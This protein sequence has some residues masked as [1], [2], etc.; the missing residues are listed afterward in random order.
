MFSPILSSHLRT[1][2][3]LLDPTQIE[4]REKRRLKE[5]DQ[6]VGGG[7]GGG[8]GGGDRMEYSKVFICWHCEQC[9]TSP[10]T[11]SD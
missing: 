3:A 4:E 8:R 1:M 6:Q 7:G 11:A 10:P 5:L 2:T 9:H